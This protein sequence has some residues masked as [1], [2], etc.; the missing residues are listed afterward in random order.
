MIKQIEDT[1]TKKN[2]KKTK[3]M[4][5]E[6]EGED[7]SPLPVVG[8]KNLRKKNPSS[9]INVEVSSGSLGGHKKRK[10][11]GSLIE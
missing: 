8:D 10:R 5:D 1:G 4:M 6:Y 2:K 7:L 9:K 3:S 11:E